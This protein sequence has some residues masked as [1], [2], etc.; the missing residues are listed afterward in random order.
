MFTNNFDSYAFLIAKA[1]PYKPLYGVRHG[2]Q[3]NDRA[4]NLLIFYT[5]PLDDVIKDDH[6]SFL[7]RL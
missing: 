2:P 7:L 4:T 1:I 6:L 3:W 5:W